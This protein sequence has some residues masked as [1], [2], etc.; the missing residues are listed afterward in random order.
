MAAA[1]DYWVNDARADPLFV[2]PVPANE[3]LLETLDQT[4]LPHVRELV[5]RRR[6]ITLVFDREGWSTKR[7][8]QWSTHDGFDVLTYRK[9]KYE[10][11][12]ESCF[13]DVPVAGGQVHYRLAE[14]PLELRAGFVVREVRRLRD[15]GHQTSVVTTR[16]DLSIGDVASRMFGRWKQENFFRYMRREFDVDHLPSNCAE[17]ILLDDPKKLVS[18]SA[19]R[20]AGKALAKTRLELAKAYGRRELK[21]RRATAVRPTAAELDLQISQLEK[22]CHDLEATLASLPAR[23]PHGELIHQK[24]IVQLER[25]RKLLCDIVKMCAYRAE[26]QMANLV[27]PLLDGHEDD[28]RTFIRT[29][30]SA[31]GDMVPDPANQRLRVRLHGLANARS[32]RALRALCD[33]V[34]A[35]QT[36]YPNTDLRLVFDLPEAPPLP[37]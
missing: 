33:I 25:E 2:V 4:I 21:K 37:Q 20:M 34:N 36:P 32:T 27:A 12:P 14:R 9:G 17:P 16:M 1:T 6:R 8:Q 23:I 19:H 31:V 35:K 26:T 22:R 28:P 30:L 10:P 15:S 11:W 13:A 5:G 24:G 29:A 3:G 7:F 18:N